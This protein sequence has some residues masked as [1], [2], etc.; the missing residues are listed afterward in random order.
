MQAKVIDNFDKL[1]KKEQ[2]EGKSKS[3]S[4]A[5][6]DKWRSFSASIMLK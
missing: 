1:K 2:E 3:H 5:K 6:T 4:N